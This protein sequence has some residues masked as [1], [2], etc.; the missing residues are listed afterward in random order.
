[1]IKITLFYPNSP[2]GRFDHDDYET[3]HMPLSIALLGGAMQSVTVERGVSA[4]A[5]WPEPAL[6]AVCS[7][8][9]KSVG[10]YGRAFTPHR[11]RLQRDMATYTHIPP[12]VQVSELLIKHAGEFAAKAV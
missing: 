6:R 9:C 10:P 11:D 5:P 7:F 4:G 8:V 12:I 2:G 3:V 1:V